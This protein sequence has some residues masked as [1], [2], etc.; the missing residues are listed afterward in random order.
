MSIFDVN[1]HYTC[2]KV[3]LDVLQALCCHMHF[4]FIIHRTSMNSQPL[5]FLLFFLFQAL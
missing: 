2:N 1:S 5:Q 4:N 3:I